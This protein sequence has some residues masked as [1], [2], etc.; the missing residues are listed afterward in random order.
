MIQKRLQKRSGM[1]ARLSSGRKHLRTVRGSS[2]DK[3]KLH[4]MLS[5]MGRGSVGGG[6]GR[7]ELN[8]DGKRVHAALYLSFRKQGLEVLKDPIDL[9]EDS[10]KMVFPEM[11]SRRSLVSRGTRGVSIS[12]SD[13]QKPHRTA[14][15]DSAALSDERTYTALT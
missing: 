12:D 14:R 4:G 13:H 11:N 8:D 7:G 3:N 5:T 6:D 1:R 10:V 9:D 2:L 15:K